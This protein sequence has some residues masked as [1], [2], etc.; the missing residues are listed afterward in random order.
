MS[1]LFHREAKDKKNVFYQLLEQLQEPL[2]V[3]F[4]IDRDRD[5]GKKKFSKSFSN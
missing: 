5:F 3:S 2:Y 4:L 1:L